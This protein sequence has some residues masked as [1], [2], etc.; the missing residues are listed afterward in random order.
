MLQARLTHYLK[1]EMGMTLISLHLSLNFI[2]SKGPNVSYKLYYK[3]CALNMQ[4]FY[5]HFTLVF[6]NG[7]CGRV[8]RKSAMKYKWYTREHIKI[9]IWRKG[10]I[11]VS[12]VF[13]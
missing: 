12:V 2:S 8:L 13:F 9:M 6:H 3:Q 7:L 5:I 4:Q 11:F 10:H 1:I